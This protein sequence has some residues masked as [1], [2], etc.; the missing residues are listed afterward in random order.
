MAASS[1]STCQLSAF[2]MA[3]L[4][5]RGPTGK[6]T[7]RQSLLSTAASYYF[8]H[9][10]HSF[11]TGDAY[12]YLCVCVCVC[13]CVCG[14]GGAPHC[15]CSTGFISL[16]VNISS[17]NRGDREATLETQ[18]QRANTVSDGNRGGRGG[19]IHMLS[20]WFWWL[21]IMLWAVSK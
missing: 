19:K 4:L 8:K 12:I 16:L 18:R 21:R 3:P 11:S 17:S 1:W 7:W 9:R 20:K 6:E 13:V 14:V 15:R 2:I 10:C 5:P